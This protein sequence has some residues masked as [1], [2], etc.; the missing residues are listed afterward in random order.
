[1]LYDGLQIRW[2]LL[3]WKHIWKR[4]ATSALGSGFHCD[5]PSGVIINDI[6]AL[7]NILDK[8]GILRWWFSGVAGMFGQPLDCAKS[9]IDILQSSRNPVCASGTD[10]GLGQPEGV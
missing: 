2:T 6:P 8:F 4:T 1:M 5:T 3:D 9:K 7:T 10:H